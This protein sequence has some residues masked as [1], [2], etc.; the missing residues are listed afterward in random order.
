MIYQVLRKGLKRHQF[1]V[2]VSAACVLVAGGLTYAGASGAPIP[3]T[4]CSNATAPC[5]QWTNT[6]T[7]P[8]ISGTSVSGRGLVGKTQF[9]SSSPANGTAGVAGFDSSSSGKYDFGVLG[10]SKLGY[11]VFG[12]SSSGFGV[13]GKAYSG[14]GVEGVNNNVGQFGAAVEALSIN[15]DGLYASTTN[16]FAA[17]SASNTSGRGVAGSSSNASGVEGD[18][19][20]GAGVAG[21]AQGSGAGV[22]GQSTGGGYGVEAIGSGSAPS[23]YVA[24]GGSGP[25][26]A[27]DTSSFGTDGIDVTASGGTMFYGYNQAGPGL[28]VTGSNYGLIGRASQSSVT[29][30]LLLQESTGNGDVFYVDGY[31]NVF[32]HGS[33]NTFLKT[34]L[35]GEAVAYGSKTSSPTV[36]DNGTAQLVNGEAT[37]RLDPAFAQTIDTSRAYQVMLTPD[38]DTKGLY[39]ASKSPTAFV[40]REV[41][42]GRSSIAFDFHIYA[43]ELGHAN[44]RIA[45]ATPA[46][47]AAMMPRPPVHPRHTWKPVAPS[48]GLERH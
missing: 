8:A 1:A 30:P 34:H 18:S 35:G 46:Q 7:G 47:L 11:G 14:V 25:G 45:V 36:E 43:P 24:G 37:I 32:Y 9:N 13:Y 19:I 12:Q 31:G 33:L 48:M 16:G 3:F 17:V 5:L 6:S 44:Q 23:L 40:V 26:E 4:N 42:G 39:I 41:Q 20:S 10:F 22:Y 28:N 38:G 27:I 2:I 29:Y 21:F 15:T